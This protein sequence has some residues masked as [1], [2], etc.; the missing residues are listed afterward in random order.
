[1]FPPPEQDTCLHC[2]VTGGEHRVWD[3]VSRWS[4]FGVA[5]VVFAFGVYRS[6][7]LWRERRLWRPLRARTVDWIDQRYDVRAPLEKI[8]R[9]PVPKYAT[10]WM[11]CLGGIT[12]TLFLVQVVTGVMLAFY[13]KPTPDEAYESI[14]YIMIGVRFGAVI[15]GIHHWAA[16]GMIVTCV[17]HMLRVFISG[18][19]KPPRELNWI[20]GILLLLIT[21]AFGFTGY[22]LIWDQRAFWATTVGSEMAGAVPIVGEI[23]LLLLRGGWTVTGA[24]LSRFYAIHVLVLPV[25]ISGLVGLHFLMVRRQGIARPL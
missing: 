12:F 24:T 16:N 1:M 22:L 20:V 18:A 14:Q 17:L 21:L 15:R 25:V 9:K 13:Y 3:P 5:G 7:S 11:Y 4:L 10:H 2:H 8:L 23:L 19:Y 6:A